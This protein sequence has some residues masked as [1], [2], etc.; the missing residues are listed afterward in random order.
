MIVPI[1]GNKIIFEKHYRYT[2]NKWT[3]ELPSGG[4]RKG[5]KFVEAA[6]KELEEELGYKTSSIREI[7]KFYPYGGIGTE[8]CHVFL[9][10]NLK[11]TGCKLEETEQIKPLEMKMK[12]AYIMAD[13]GKI[14]DGMTLAALLI[15]KKFLKKMLK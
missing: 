1:K 9:A 5:E 4:A 14:I 11:F 6:K 10:E 8:V 2:I 7:G 15:A 3:I 12:D 13:E